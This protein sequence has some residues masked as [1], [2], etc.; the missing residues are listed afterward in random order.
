MQKMDATLKILM[1]QK[2]HLLVKEKKMPQTAT[3]LRYPGGKSKLLPLVTNI[4]QHHC[5]HGGLVNYIEPY[6]GGGRFG[7][8]P[9]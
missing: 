1:D 2:N 8:K 9:A 6:A 7:I 3:P 5:H 4:L